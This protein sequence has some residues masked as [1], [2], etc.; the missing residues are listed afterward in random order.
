MKGKTAYILQGTTSLNQGPFSAVQKQGPFF[1][2]YN[3]EEPKKT[4]PPPHS[5]AH[6]THLYIVFRIRGSSNTV[7]VKIKILTSENKN[8]STRI[9][10]NLVYISIFA[11]SLHMLRSYGKTICI[12]AHNNDTI[13]LPTIQSPCSFRSLS[14]NYINR[15]EA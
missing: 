9:E 10:K 13:K 12:P 14:A 7:S 6:R 2:S 15:T 8:M 3:R 4:P 1:T 11:V 5:I